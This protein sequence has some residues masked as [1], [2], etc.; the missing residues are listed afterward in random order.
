MVYALDTNIVI[1]YLRNHPNVHQ[2][3]NDAVMQGNDL[4]IPKVV[5]YEMRRGFRI[6][7]A[8]SKEAAY[9]ILTCEGYCDVAEMD[10]YSWERAEHV[11]AELYHKGL[12]IGEMDILIAAFCRENDYTLVTNNTKHFENIDGLQLV[13]WVK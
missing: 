11:Y 8:P 5:D 2:N 3:F 13:N 10:V 7:H 9:K 1:H 4:V 6:L 12:T